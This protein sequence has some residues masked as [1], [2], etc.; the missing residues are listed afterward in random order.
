M[1]AQ[2]AREMKNKMYQQKQMQEYQL[3]EAKK[4]KEFEA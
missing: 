4:R 3:S 2:K 1:E